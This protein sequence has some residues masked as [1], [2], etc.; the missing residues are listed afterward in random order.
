VAEE[1]EVAD[2]LARDELVEDDE[3]LDDED[4]L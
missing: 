4:A 1:E 3:E 2:A